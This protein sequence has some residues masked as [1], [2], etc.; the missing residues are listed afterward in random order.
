MNRLK[1]GGFKLKEDCD[2]NDIYLIN[3][4]DHIFKIIEILLTQ[5]NKFIIIISNF[6]NFREV[7][8]NE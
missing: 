2:L 3:K 7:W 6:F 5:K 8:K 1:E 4:N